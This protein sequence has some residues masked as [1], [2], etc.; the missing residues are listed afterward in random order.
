MRSI[1]HLLASLF[2]LAFST[3]ILYSQ[4][5]SEVIA[6]LDKYM[7]ELEANDE[8]M[9]ILSISKNGKVVYSKA[10]GFSNVEKG[11]K[12]TPNT[13]MKIGSNTKVF[14]ATMIFQLIDE[15]KITLDTKLSDFH[16]E[17]KNAGKITI[18]QMLR[19]KSGIFEMI[20]DNDFGSYRVKGLTAEEQLKKIASFDSKF[21]PGS[22][23]EYSNTNY[24]LLSYI[25][26]KITG[27]S[28]GKNLSERITDK[29]NLSH[30]FYAADPGV[31]DKTARGYYYEDSW[32]EIPST[33]MNLPRGAGAIVSTADELNQFL[34]A[35]MQGKLMSKASLEKMTDFEEGRGRGINGFEVPP[36]IT[37]E[38]AVSHGGQIDG[39]LA[40]PTY[41]PNSDIALTFIS[42]G[43]NCPPQKIIGLLAT[44]VR[45]PF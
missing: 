3:G 27:I 25:I 42:N 30:T 20:Q 33:S 44:Y 8:A 38:K 12:L 18:S 43:L 2:L 4:N 35:L 7:D 14:T 6:Q 17:L 26:E 1:K 40:Q 37:T 24:I 11:T 36:S 39:F 19:H 29:L 22:Q 13:I 41:F 15:G 32:N 45:N 31:L 9:G 23:Y 28:Y 16:P 21:E 10:I 5:K 34:R